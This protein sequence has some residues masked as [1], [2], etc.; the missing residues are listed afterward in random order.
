[1][2]VSGE[3][4][5]GKTALLE[6]FHDRA[7]GLR[8]LW[9]ACDGLVMP[10]PLGPLFDIGLQVDGELGDL[11]RR[12]A[13][14]DRLFE[15]FLREVGSRAA[16]T[17]AVIEDVHWADDASID[18]LNYVGRRIARSPALVLA[19]YR[20]DEL[21]DDHPL[22]LVLGDLATQRGTRRMQLSPLSLQAV[23]ALAG[24]RD[25]DV[26]EL[27]RVTSGNP[28]YVNE[29]LE[30]GWPSI[31]PTVRDAIA[32]RLARSAPG[33]RQMA[34]VAAVIGPKAETSLMTSICEASD[35][36][37]DECLATG[38][39]V[40]DGAHLRFRH[41]LVR[42]AVA[43]AVPPH[44]KTELHAVA[45][46]MLE[47]RDSC[48][49]AVLA[50]HAAGA[51]NGAAV[52][53]HASEAGWRSAAL[54]ARREAAAQFERALAFTDEGDRENRAA[55]HEAAASQYSL[56]DRWQQAD[57][58]LL[59]AIEL[60][61]SLGDDLRVGDDL[62]LLSLA[63]SAL[64]NGKQSEQAAEESVLVL[65]RLGPSTE[66]AWAYATLGAAYLS[67]GRPDEGLDMLERAR[68][69]A[70]ELRVP[71]LVSFTLNGLGIG[72]TARGKDGTAHIEQALRI[73]LAADLQEHA[74][75]AYAS[76]QEVAIAM[77]RFD[78]AERYFTDGAAYCADHEIGVFSLC[79]NGSRAQALL[80]RGR[81][82]EAAE[83][84]QRLLERRAISPV[85]RLKPL[86]I[87]G[88]IRGR[89]GETGA[90]EALDEGLALAE[91]SDERQW[92]VAALLARAELR[93]LAGERELAADDVR[94][95][96]NKM[97]EPADPWM[98]GAVLTW[99]ARLC[100]PVND[101]LEVPEPFARE[102][103]GARQDAVA[104]WHQLGRPY[105]AALVQLGACDEA[106]LRNALAT[107]EDLGARSA[108]ACARRRM[109]ELGF[110]AIP[111]GPRA[112]TRAAPGGLTAREQEVLGLL[113]QG[114]RNREISRRLYI[115]ERTVDHHVSAVLAKIGVSS[116]SAAAR[117]AARIGITSRA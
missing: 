46:A 86:R 96:H 109:K 62:R 59:V 47:R 36:A 2:L 11:C 32:G 23:G 67:V 106:D 117:E 81:W 57:A 88:L 99:L 95:A 40:H 28:F 1:V 31:P 64:C 17:V 110:R 21:P 87:L 111:R 43:A 27:H 15:A 70:E 75:R 29:V 65:E 42:M 34:E 98:R 97:P 53:R 22:R 108:A 35:A 6:A 44:R 20:D 13:V 107:F 72:L 16:G 58:A 105:D 74:G 89:R 60:R 91:Q 82:D 12:S 26:A 48:D 66:L 69:L 8:W 37:I 52:L 5:L 33:I 94:A 103:S 55:L 112:A 101:S 4:G 7:K 24:D 41:E 93:W 18:L 14:R 84:C 113:T 83:I 50:H 71:D 116:R 54:G 3:S 30:A 85:N 92:I 73:A 39:F 25:I 80:L 114:L 79:M 61:R 38:I 90:W 51:G 10:R 45:L 19:T 68:A 115:S 63:R 56:L 77:H 78:D 76:L 104:S 100:E 9:G 49:P 102:R